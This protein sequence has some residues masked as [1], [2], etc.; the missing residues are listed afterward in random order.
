[1][2]FQFCCPQGHVLQ[3]ELSQVGQLFQ[4]PMCGANFLIPP[5]TMD[6]AAMGN[7]AVAGGLFP[8]PGTWPAAGA[9]GPAFPAQGPMPGF[10]PP[11]GMPMMPGSPMPSGPMPVGPYPMPAVQPFSFGPSAVNPPAAGPAVPPE[12][13]QQPPATTAQ[14][15]T[16]SRPQFDLGFD[17]D[18]KESLPFEIP[19]ESEPAAGQTPTLPFSPAAPPRRRFPTECFL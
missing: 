9:P 14:S 3:G 10:M 2:S 17:P 18:A 1:M 8:G 11:Q 16:G 13:P 6:P 4:C 7:R 15:E 12:P 19:G 5:P